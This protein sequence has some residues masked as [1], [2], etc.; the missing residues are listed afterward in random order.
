M[1]RYEVIAILSNGATLRADAHSLHRANIL[2]GGIKEGCIFK[3][4]LKYENDEDGSPV[5]VSR[6]Y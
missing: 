3:C 5:V 6:S 1:V 2:S 4:I